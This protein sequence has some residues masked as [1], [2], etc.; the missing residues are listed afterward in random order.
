MG[1]HEFNER[2]QGM[3]QITRSPKSFKTFQKN[4]VDL[5]K[6]FHQITGD[7]RDIHRLQ[8]LNHNIHQFFIMNDVL[9]I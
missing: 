6:C 1:L 5:L 3:G 7:Y 8:R 9:G 2:L 4:M